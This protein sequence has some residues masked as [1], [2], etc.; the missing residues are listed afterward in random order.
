MGVITHRQHRKHV[1]DEEEQEHNVNGPEISEWNYKSKGLFVSVGLL[2]F[3]LVLF[4]AF[5]ISQTGWDGMVSEAI[6]R[7]QSLHQADHNH[8]QLCVRGRMCV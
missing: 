6:L 7:L 5:V 8:A 2:W 4:W 3:A 1:N